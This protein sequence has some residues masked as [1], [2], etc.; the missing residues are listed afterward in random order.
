MVNDSICT[1]HSTNMLLTRKNTCWPN[2]A[3]CCLQE[4]I[5]DHHHQHAKG[6]VDR[7]EL[8]PRLPL[9]PSTTGSR[10]QPLRCKQGVANPQSSTTKEVR[11]RAHAAQDAGCIMKRRMQHACCAACNLH[12]EVSMLP[13]LVA[14]CC[15]ACIAH[16]CDV[17]SLHTAQHAAYMHAMYSDVVLGC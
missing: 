5:K 12:H 11:Y 10:V 17:Q 1:F 14:P 7:P 13:E 9:A 2:V 8:K 16:A 4:Q 3:I 6:H 15:T